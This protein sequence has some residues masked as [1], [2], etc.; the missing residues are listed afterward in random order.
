[1]AQQYDLSLAT[2]ESLIYCT[3]D[4]LVSMGVQAFELCVRPALDNVG[5]AVDRC[6]MA[7]YTSFAAAGLPC[8]I[9]G[10][11]GGHFG[12]QELSEAPR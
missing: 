12:K 6:K 4:R 3:P 2:P 8:P 10:K 1:M 9:T 11:S 7:I 5:S